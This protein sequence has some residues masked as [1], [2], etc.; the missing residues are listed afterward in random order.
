LLCT[1]IQ[2]LECGYGFAKPVK[3][4]RR[5]KKRRGV[6][7]FYCSKSCATTAK[8]K[9]SRIPCRYIYG[10]AKR[11]AETREIEFTITLEDL[12]AVWVKQEGRC[13]LTGI[14][15]ELPNSRSNGDLTYRA[16]IDRIDNDKGYT[17]G[18]IQILS[19]RVNYMKMRSKNSEVIEFIRLIRESGSSRVRVPCEQTC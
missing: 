5:E 3:E 17:R 19:L 9:G 7:Q 14:P 18:N 11:N 2:C 6:E 8:N 1:S 15:L 16:S 12:E 4:I 13:K 10:Q